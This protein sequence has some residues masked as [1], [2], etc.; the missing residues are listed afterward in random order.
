[1]NRLCIPRNRRL[2]IRGLGKTWDAMAACCWQ[3]TGG[4]VFARFWR[5]EPDIEDPVVITAL[6]SEAGPGRQIS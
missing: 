5:R 6:L 3:C 1:M 2:V 4:A